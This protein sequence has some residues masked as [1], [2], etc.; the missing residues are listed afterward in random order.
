MTKTDITKRYITYLAGL[1][2]LAMGLA[3]IICS[4]LGTSPISSWAYV[5]SNNTP[6]SVGTYTV[7][8][9]TMMIFGQCLVLHHHGLRNQIVNIVLQLPCSFLF[10]AFIDLN[11]ILVRGG[12]LP[13][14]EPLSGCGIAGDYASC[15]LVLLLGIAVQSYGVVLE[16]K[17]KVTMMSAEALVYYISDRWDKEFGG[18]KVI[19]DCFLVLMAVV[20]SLIFKLTPEHIADVGFM[21]AFADG[22]L[23]GVREGTVIAALAV[24]RLVRY[25]ARHTSWIDRMLS[26]K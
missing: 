10:G 20:F 18:I 1:Y 24:G 9:N 25:F 7:I 14:L 19:F 23:G 2:V 13:L 17:P 5:M 21:S 12:L 4:G 8:I 26:C 16:V 11:I 3:L 22:I 6:A 15:M